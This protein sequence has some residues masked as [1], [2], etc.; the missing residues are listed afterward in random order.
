MGNI[1]KGGTHQV[2]TGWILPNEM[3]HSTFHGGFSQPIVP[4]GTKNPA[5]S[6]GGYL[7]KIPDLCV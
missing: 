7:S 6:R 1:Q 3:I 5:E 4:W 2:T